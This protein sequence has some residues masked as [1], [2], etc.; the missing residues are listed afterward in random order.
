MK[1]TSDA[2]K[3]INSM[4]KNDPELQ[5]MVRESSI[6]AQVADIVYQTRESAGLSQEQLAA[7]VGINPSVIAKLE[8]AEDLVDCLSILA[9]I[10]VALDRHLEIRLIPKNVTLA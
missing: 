7:L 3:I 9:K 10:T 2:L 6:S 5:E 4:M 1:T 8:D